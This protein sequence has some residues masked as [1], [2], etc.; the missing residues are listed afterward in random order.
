MPSRKKFRVEEDAAASSECGM[1]EI[2]SLEE[3]QHLAVNQHISVTGKIVK[4]QSPAVR[5]SRE[6]QE[7]IHVPE[8][9]PVL[10][11]RRH[12]VNE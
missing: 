12:L 8:R 4:Q 5:H 6:R 2:A 11:P 9:R 1:T 7:V 10:T 3:V